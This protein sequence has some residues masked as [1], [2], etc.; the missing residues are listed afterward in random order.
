MCSKILTELFRFVLENLV[1]AWEVL[2]SAGA[3]TA[4]LTDPPFFREGFAFQHSGTGTGRNWILSILALWRRENEPPP[5][6][7]RRHDRP[8]YSAIAAFNQFRFSAFGPSFFPQIERVLPVMPIV[9]LPSCPETLFPPP[10]PSGAVCLKTIRRGGERER[11]RPKGQ[12][13]SSGRRLK[14]S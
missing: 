1:Y 10:S 9:D 7:R 3:G 13:T 12:D 14:K 2:E 6:I 4:V 8:P 5:L 11:I